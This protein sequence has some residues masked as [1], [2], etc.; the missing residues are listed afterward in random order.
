MLRHEHQSL[1]HC[2]YLLFI[3]FFFISETAL[4]GRVYFI[5]FLWSFTNKCFNSLVTWFSLIICLSHGVYTRIFHFQAIYL[6][7]DSNT[8]LCLLPVHTL[9][10]Y[11]CT[12]VSTYR[13]TGY[14]VLLLAESTIIIVFVVIN[15]IF[16][17]ILVIRF[18]V[19]NAMHY[20][21]PVWLG[22]LLINKQ[23]MLLVL[24]QTI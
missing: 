17:I 8:A 5:C 3:V 14:K 16:V 7:H 2:I 12:A 13:E 23:Y 18:L 21:R 4:Y 20:D 9:Q 15:V 19:Y 6:L 11:F 22:S 1:Y 10:R 24:L